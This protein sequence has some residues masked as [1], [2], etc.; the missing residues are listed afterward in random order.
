MNIP[1]W[2]VTVFGVG[3]LIVKE[4]V[5]PIMGSIF[6]FVY[7]GLYAYIAAAI[8]SILWWF[9]GP[10]KRTLA[11]RKLVLMKRAFIN[12]YKLALFRKRR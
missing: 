12:G 7:G 10:I 3:W 6:A 9:R 11:R 4:G 5:L 1:R 8:L 2:F